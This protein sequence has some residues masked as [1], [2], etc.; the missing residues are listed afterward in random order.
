MSQNKH[1]LKELPV[2]N[3][4]PA[5]SN[6]AIFLVLVIGAVVIMVAAVILVTAFLNDQGQVQQNIYQNVI[7]SL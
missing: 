2:E 5:K 3:Q 1:Q 7:S 6:P 4:E